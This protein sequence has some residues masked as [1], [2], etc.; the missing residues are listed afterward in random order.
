M[1]FEFM[2]VSPYGVYVFVG[3]LI[4]IWVGIEI[5]ERRR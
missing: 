5:W 1:L 2:D 4:L 3:V